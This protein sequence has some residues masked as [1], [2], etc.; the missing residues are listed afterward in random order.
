MKSVLALALSTLILFFGLGALAL[1]LRAPDNAAPDIA[2]D[3]VTQ[4]E[5]PM[6]TV[7]GIA[8]AITKPK[9]PA[10][11]EIVSN[12]WLNSPP[13]TRE[14]LRGKVVVVEFWTYG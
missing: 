4:N 10:A 1:I 11:P 5:E 2:A 6:S 14:N 3:Q 8:Q 12:T 9:G 13:L 7:R